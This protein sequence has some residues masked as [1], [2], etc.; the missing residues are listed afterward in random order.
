MISYSYIHIFVL[1]HIDMEAY[2]FSGYVKT[3]K[4]KI[5]RQDGII[6]TRGQICCFVVQLL[7]HVQLLGTSQTAAQ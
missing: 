1:K 5:S 3:E 7:S 4:N 2:A 6:I